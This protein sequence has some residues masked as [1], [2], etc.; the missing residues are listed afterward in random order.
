MQADFKCGEAARGGRSLGWS[1]AILAGVPLVATLALYAPNAALAACG[2]SHPAGVHAA[3]GGGGVHVATSMPATS[4]GGGGGGVGTLGC[5]N[6]AS[7]AALR[8]LPMASSG[9]VVE[10]GAHAMARP[11]TRA[12][13]FSNAGAHVH[14][15]RPGHRA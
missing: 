8:G 3:G 15:V 14:A 6:G 13:T 7:A 9:R 4:G 2:A 1:V 5:A 11:T 12:K 10:A